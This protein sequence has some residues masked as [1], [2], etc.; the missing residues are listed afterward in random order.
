MESLEQAP[1]VT[2]CGNCNFQ[3][4]SSQKFCSQCSFPIGGTE[5]EVRNFR[6]IVSSR[7][8]LLSDAEDKIRS[9]KNIIYFLAG[10]FFVFGLITWFTSK[11]LAML[12]IHLLMCILYL[13]FAAWSNKNP[14]AAILTAFII[15]ITLQVINAFAD[16]VT[17]FSGII[18]KVIFIGALIKGIHSALEAQRYMKELQ[19]FK[20]LSIGAD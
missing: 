17:I 6:L 1:P 12:V 19:K 14:F 18:L 15:Y 5:E 20:A 13:I 8:R 10:A 3:N 2:S 11:D 16:P 7:K 4:P 9:A